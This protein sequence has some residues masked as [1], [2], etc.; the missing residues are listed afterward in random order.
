M[1]CAPSTGS[2]VTHATGCDLCWRC[3]VHDDAHTGEHAASGAAGTAFGAAVIA[4]VSLAIAAIPE[5][6][7]MVYTL[8]LAMGA[9]RLAQHKALVRRLCDRLRAC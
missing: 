6:F 3:V 7:S 1:F 8:Y 2:G 4:G 5:E 9:W